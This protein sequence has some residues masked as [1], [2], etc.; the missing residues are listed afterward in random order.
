MVLRKRPSAQSVINMASAIGRDD[1]VEYLVSMKH[2][3]E[4][5]LN[6]VARLEALGCTHRYDTF[7]IHGTGNTV[8]ALM[9][10]ARL[11]IEGRRYRHEFFFD[12]SLLVLAL[13]W[14]LCAFFVPVRS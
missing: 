2:A 5:A 6:L 1:S 10:I 13:C 3:D 8:R 7:D 9:A 12:T 14:L 11:R 4:S